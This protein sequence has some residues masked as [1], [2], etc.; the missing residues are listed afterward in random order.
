MLSKYFLKKVSLQNF[1][2]N[3]KLSLI[4]LSGKK[5]IIYGAGEGFNYFYDE[6]SLDKLNIVAIAD[7]KFQ[8]ETTFMN[9]KAI[10]PEQIFYQ[11][12]DVILVTN[13]QAKEIYFYLRKTMKIR[14]KDIRCILNEDFNDEKDSF[15]Y[16]EMFGFA[17]NLKK[18]KH[19]IGDKKVVIY[20][21]GVF[22]ETIKKYYDLSALNIIGISDRKFE[23]HAEN[24]K[25]LGYKVY[26]PS[27]I[28]DLKPDFVLV[29][30]KF[31]INVI[32]NLYYNTLKGSKIKIKPLMKKPFKTLLRE[33]WT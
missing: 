31:C 20:G 6:Y 8:E 27:E 29:A 18:L 17:D 9:Y 4:E 28:K 19:K 3:L 25:F 15:L 23:Q 1:K 14:D 2:D 11:N 5:V 32:E 22:F 10:P 24:E 30:T 12:Y 16:L 26:S 33:I 21:A 13:E 7:K